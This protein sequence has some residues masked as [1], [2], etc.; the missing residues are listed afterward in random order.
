MKKNKKTLIKEQRVYHR[1]SS[2]SDVADRVARRAAAGVIL[3]AG[4]ALDRAAAPDQADVP[5]AKRAAAGAARGAREVLVADIVRGSRRCWRGWRRPG[6]VRALLRRVGRHHRDPA[7]P[8]AGVDVPLHTDVTSLAPLRAPRVADDPVVLP[9]LGAVA[10]RDDTMVKVRGAA[11][12]EDTLT[13][14]NQR[15]VV[16]NSTAGPQ[17]QGC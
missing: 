10:D 3:A 11:S 9:V 8:S 17:T 14:K 1:A 16:K 13:K 6:R 4:G 12:A 5:E 7:L 2:S 15:H